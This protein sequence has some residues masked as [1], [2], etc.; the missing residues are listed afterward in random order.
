M[1]R[2][3]QGTA[4]QI[5]PETAEVMWEHANVADPYGIYPEC[6]EECIGNVFR[7]SL[8][9]RRPCSPL[10]MTRR[11]LRLVIATT[12]TGPYRCAEAEATR[13]FR[14]NVSE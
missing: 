6:P 2:D 5:D 1:A 11:L 8:R 7:P 12:R 13:A 3:P 4:L 10:P 14:P 9:K